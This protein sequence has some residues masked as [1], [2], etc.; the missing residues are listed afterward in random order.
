MDL[1][2]LLIGF[3]L[4]VL[5]QFFIKEVLS[6]YMILFCF[7]TSFTFIK[8][9]HNDIV[10]RSPFEWTLYHLLTGYNFWILGIIGFII[11]W[12]IFYQVI[13]KNKG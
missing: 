5:G 3:L 11:S 4:G 2:Y 7:G 13:P 10:M 12:I 9:F 6:L 1:T 8:L